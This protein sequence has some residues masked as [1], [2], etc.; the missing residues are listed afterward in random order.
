[1]EELK[2][3]DIEK[4]KKYV[5]AKIREE[6]KRKNITIEKIKWEE[7]PDEKHELTFFANNNI[8]DKKFSTRNLLGKHQLN[9]ERQIVSIIIRLNKIAGC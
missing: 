4:G 1:M 9:L 6:A 7:L 2:V 8:V 5:E 3:G